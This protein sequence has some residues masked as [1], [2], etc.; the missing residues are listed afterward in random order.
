MASHLHRLADEDADFV[1]RFVQQFDS[2]HVPDT[3]RAALQ[4]NDQWMVGN[5]FLAII[6]VWLAWMICVRTERIAPLRWLYAAS[7][8]AF[9][10]NSQYVIT[11]LI[12]LVAE[13]R[14][15]GWTLPTFV[16]LV[17]TYIVFVV[18]GVTCYGVVAE[19]LAESLRGRIG[20]R[21]TLFVA[22]P[23]LHVAC[24]AGVYLGRVIR[25]NSWQFVTD[26]HAVA[27][28]IRIMFTR[29]EAIA[30]IAVLAIASAL[31]V[32]VLRPIWL[33][34]ALLIRKYTFS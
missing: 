16:V 30:Y 1:S 33:R 18:I 27:V 29:I 12:H 25:L 23:T 4:S 24:S 34:I 31:L 32:W 3:V 9:L 20:R 11:D 28:G 19:F 2:G 26:P 6:P 15:I 21:V 8:I 13:G 7:L 14:S 5:T 17:P 22:L 10:P